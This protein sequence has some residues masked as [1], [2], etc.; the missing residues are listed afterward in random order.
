MH[1]ASGSNVWLKSHAGGCPASDGLVA[2]HAAN[3]PRVTS[4][5][6]IQYPPGSFTIAGPPVSGHGELGPSTS[7]ASPSAASLASAS[8]A[9]PPEPPSALEPAAPSGWPPLPPNVRRGWCHIR[10]GRRGH[11]LVSSASH[12]EQ[13]RDENRRLPSEH[14][15][16]LLSAAPPTPS[17]SGGMRKPVRASLHRSK[18]QL[19]IYTSIVRR[20]AL[21]RGK[22]ALPTAPAARSGAALDTRIAACRYA[23]AVQRSHLAC[24]TGIRG[25]AYVDVLVADL[26]V[27]AAAVPARPLCRTATSITDP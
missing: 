21:L 10:C 6:S 18:P 13:H 16:C 27:R 12:Q 25:V 4:V 11:L 5:P 14:V 26:A 8:L 20:H 23:V 22:A 7:A 1:V 17:A 9:C 3:G 15:C 24:G 2:S 19:G